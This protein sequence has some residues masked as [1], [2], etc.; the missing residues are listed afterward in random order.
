MTTDDYIMIKH[1]DVCSL[2]RILSNYKESEGNVRC[3]VQDLITGS[4]C[5]GCGHC[6]FHERQC[7]Y[8]DYNYRLEGIA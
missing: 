3:A 4:S 1:V 5:G 6:R 2:R 7:C 8:G